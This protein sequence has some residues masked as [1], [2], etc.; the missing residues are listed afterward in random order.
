M[1][2]R[3]TLLC[4]CATLLTLGAC[5]TKKIDTKAIDNLNLAITHLASLS[6]AKSDVKLIMDAPDRNIK[7]KLE[8]NIEL[9]ME[10]KLEM[11]MKLHGSAN[12]IRLD[13]IASFYVKD[14]ILYTD[15]MGSVQ[16]KREITASKGKEDIKQQPPVLTKEDVEKSF[17]EVS[18]KEEDGDKIIHIV[19]TDVAK[20]D[21]IKNVKKQFEGKEDVGFETIKDV[22]IDVA[23][24]KNNELKSAVFY[25]DVI[26]KDL[27]KTPVQSVP[28]NMKLELSIHAFN[29]LKNIEFPD[30]KDFM[31]APDA[32]DPLSILD[33]YI[34]ESIDL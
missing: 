28:M 10:D 9:L 6:S 16:E 21:L 34:G 2:K 3:T 20:Q 31:I 23:I 18:M 24:T 30:F 25:I 15:V 7:A 33:K 14:N 8:L 11:K 1:K 27:T 26:Y 5:S 29:T 13:D 17:K 32:D 12:G 22:S 4:I 19:P